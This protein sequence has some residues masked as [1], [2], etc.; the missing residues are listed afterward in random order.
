MPLAHSNQTSFLESQKALFIRHKNRLAVVR[1]LKAK[2]KLELFGKQEVLFISFHIICFSE[3]GGC[4]LKN[5]RCLISQNI[6]NVLML[7]YIYFDVFL[8]HIK[9]SSVHLVLNYFLLLTD[10]LFLFYFR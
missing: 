10:S 9:C 3:D 6:F 1:E 2:A 7:V 8:N 5:I 4:V